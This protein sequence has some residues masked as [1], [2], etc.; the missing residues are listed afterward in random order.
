[1]FSSVLLLIFCLIIVL[2]IFAIA[3]FRP[4]KYPPG[5]FITFKRC[6]SS[7]QKKYYAGPKWRFPL[8]GNSCM[9]RKLS[10]ELKGQHKAFEYLCD[11][12]NSPVIGFKL[13]TELVIY[14]RSYEIVKQIHSRDEFDGRP[15]NFF[16]RLRTM[17]T[18]LGITCTGD[19]DEASKNAKTR[20]DLK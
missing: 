19:E 6:E 10:K 2:T 8:I 20:I 3:S 16:L 9:L 15:D 13:G 17:G 12:Y 11:K 18:R 14:A 7:Y 4:N 1:M 5:E